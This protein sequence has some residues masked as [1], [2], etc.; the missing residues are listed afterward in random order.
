MSR[1][2]IPATIPGLVIAWTMLWVPVVAQSPGPDGLSGPASQPATVAALRMRSVALQTD[3][4]RA[5]L[6]AVIAGGPGYI[7][8]G[9]TED[10]GAEP[11][12]SLILTSPDGQAWTPVDSDVLSGTKLEDIA[13]FPGGYVAVGST[14]DG[15]IYTHGLVLVSVDG[16]E[17]QRASGREFAGMRLHGVTPWADGVA[18]VG[19]VLDRDG[20]WVRSLV[21]TSVD[22]LEWARHRLPRS[23]TQPRGIGAGES[24]LAVLDSMSTHAGA[25][26]VTRPVV[27]TTSDL[28]SWTRRELGFEGELRSVVV[29]GDHVIAAGS[30]KDPRGREHGVLAYSPNAGRRWVRQPLTAPAGSW[31]TDISRDGPVIAFGGLWD[32]DREE[33]APAAW[34]STI[35]VDWERI[36]GAPGGGPAWIEDFVAFPDRPGGIAV[37]ASG[38]DYDRPAVWV[39]EA[40]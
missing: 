7:A 22:G 29:D 40:D 2:W 8:V 13:A 24:L 3:L 1:R 14:S 11:E 23:I 4:T 18:V 19:E 9:A 34:T 26:D 12:D 30:M 39:I 27:V 31:F 5:P 21:I 17:W 28:G 20:V 38:E 36:P 6:S 32:E 10:F 35:G 37:G 33:H 25:E 16:L 15:D